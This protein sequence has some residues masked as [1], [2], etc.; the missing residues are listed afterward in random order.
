MNKER[1]KA[2]E[3]K[4][5]V[6]NCIRAGMDYSKT[7][8]ELKKQGLRYPNLA[9]TFYTWQ[10]AIFPENARTQALTSLG[11]KRKA[12]EEEKGGILAAISPKSW[13]KQKQKEVDESVISDVI[14]EALFNFI[15]CPN[16][17]LKIEDVKQ[18]NVGGSI[19][20]LVVYYTDINLNHPL[21]VFVLRTIMLVI[22]VRAL[23]YKVQ[24]KVGAIQS[25]VEDLR[26]GA[27][28]PPPPEK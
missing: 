28:S 13:S 16:K 22:K 3:V 4:P 7:R 8:K 26:K 27:W 24:E 2:K 20:G 11:E 23:C 10:Q 21:V 18:I 25:K 14:N 1:V 19:T 15:P 17:N 6:E 5:I 9:K 12:K